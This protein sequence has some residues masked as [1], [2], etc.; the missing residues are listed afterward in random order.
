LSRNTPLKAENDYIVQKVGGA[1][2]LS[3]SPWLRLWQQSRA[4]SAKSAVIRMCDVTEKQSN[5]LSN[6]KQLQ[7]THC[8]N[9]GW[10]TLGPNAIRV[11]IWYCPHQK[12]RYPS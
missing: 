9:Q 11:N 1:G 4:E 6:K 12:F 8:L 3:T 7:S 5:I 2:P 10:G